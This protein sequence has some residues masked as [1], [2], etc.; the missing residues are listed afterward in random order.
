VEAAREPGPFRRVRATRSTAVCRRHLLP[1][2][3]AQRSAP[4]FQQTLESATRTR[5]TLLKQGLHILSPT[6]SGQPPWR[7]SRWRSCQ[8]AAAIRTT[9]R[10]ARAAPSRTGCGGWSGSS[11]I[12]DEQPLGPR[13][14]PLKAQQQ[15]PGEGACDGGEG[16][17]GGPAAAA[18]CAGASR[19]PWVRRAPPEAPDVPRLCPGPAPGVATFPARSGRPARSQAVRR[20]GTCC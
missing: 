11:P 10:T 15:A 3:A 8:C 6:G 9:P 17:A 1:A 2:T 13:R 4:W 18:A 12:D 7:G 19:A 5:F 20:V 14:R 16:A